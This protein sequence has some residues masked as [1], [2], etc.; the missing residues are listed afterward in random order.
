MRRILPALITVL[1]VSTIFGWPILLP[2]DLKDY[3]KSL[4]SA[5]AS[6]SN[7]YFFKYLDFGHF[8][9]DATI[10]PLLH[11]WSQSCLIKI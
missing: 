9:T 3:S 6:V 11:T 5:L 1:I 10:I 2:E 7:L 4:V 8:S